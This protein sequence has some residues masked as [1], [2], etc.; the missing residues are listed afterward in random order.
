M[1]TT[2]CEE[3]EA[4]SYQLNYLRHGNLLR[5]IKKHRVIRKLY[6]IVRQ[7]HLSL[8]WEIKCL[9]KCWPPRHTKLTSLL[10]HFMVLTQIIEHTELGVVVWPI[11][12]TQIEPIR[13]A[14]DRIRR[15]PDKIPAC[16]HNTQKLNKQNTSGSTVDSILSRQQSGGAGGKKN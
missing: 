9:Y 11:D 10:N 3:I 2:S 13:V 4:D 12:K 5:V 1:D 6:M 7:N 15:C 8:V 14:Y 16:S